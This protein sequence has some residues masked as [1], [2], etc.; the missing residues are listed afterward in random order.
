MPPSNA[1]FLISMSC[2]AVFLSQLGMMMYL[3]ALPAIAQ[4]L[5]TTQHL[6]S[7]ALPVYL[8]GMALPMLMWGKWGAT[9]GIQRIIMLSLLLFGISSALLSVCTQIETFISL[10]F[11]QGMA[12]SGLSVMARSLIAQHFKGSELAKALSWLSIAFV[13]SLGIGQYA[14]AV[15][16][17]AL[18]WPAIFWG[19]GA[20]SF[21]LMMGV[22][23]YLPDSPHVSHSPVCW[24]HYL[25]LVRHRPFL[26]PAMMGGLGYGII[27]GFNTAAPSIFQ[28]TYQWSAY[29]YGQLGWAMS[30]AYLLG[31][32]SVNRYVT[33]LGQST[34]SRMA[35]RAMLAASAVMMAGTLISSTYAL[36]LWLPYCL[37]ICGQAIIYPISLSQASEH[38]PVSGP[39]AMALC[40]FI[41][42]VLA[43]V[44]GAA[45]SLLSVQ[46]PIA[47]AG[48]CLLLVIMVLGMKLMQPRA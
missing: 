9:F 29:D 46:N 47:L 31:S 7:L 13:I 32:L 6:T 1:A 25:T 19:L 12:A 36:L 45:V 30:L 23:A 20:A 8:A 48:I 17:R 44:I 38:S 26:L 15:L 41:H 11:V 37:L 27:I 21:I 40:G 14:G 43:A 2:L 22:F 34:M 24:R 18:D 10:R 33:G 5:N 42:Q 4:A 28:N 3:P 39:Y 35:I 16:M